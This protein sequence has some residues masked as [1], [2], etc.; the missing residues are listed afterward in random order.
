MSG[1]TLT[2]GTLESGASY[3]PTVTGSDEIEVIFPSGV[4]VVGNATLWSSPR[5]YAEW[6]DARR[7]DYD[8]TVSN[9][10]R[11]FTFGDPINALEFY[12][13][14]PETIQV[15]IGYASAVYDNFR[16]AQ[17]RFSS[18]IEQEIAGYIS[19]EIDENFNRANRKVRETLENLL[20]TLGITTAL[21]KAMRGVVIVSD[22]VNRMLSNITDLMNRGVNLINSFVRDKINLVNG[23]INS[24]YS[25]ARQVL[26]TIISVA[27]VPFDMINEIKTRIQNTIRRVELV[28]NGKIIED[29]RKNFSNAINIDNVLS[30]INTN[31]NLTLPSVFSNSLG[32]LFSQKTS[33]FVS[34]NLLSNLD[35]FVIGIRDPL[36]FSAAETFRRDIR[37]N[38]RD[39]VRPIVERHV[40]DTKQREDVI[41]IIVDEIDLGKDFCLPSLVQCSKG[42][43]AQSTNKVRD[44]FELAFNDYFE[45]IIRSIDLKPCSDQDR[46][47]YLNF[48]NNVKNELE[49]NLSFEKRG[50]SLEEKKRNEDYLDCVLVKGYD[51]MRREDLQNKLAEIDEILNRNIEIC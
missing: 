42:I 5:A 2:Q 29:L 43:K 17:T 44:A 31:L 10:T 39:K 36:G 18:F 13:S 51:R 32:S 35:Q 38:V 50:V 15:P 6:I 24:V 1:N 23:F 49:Q 12:D 19:A 25:S 16:E 26:N 20:A 46:Q 47:D 14:I 33:S 8:R 11:D 21:D 45:D 27:R 41:D 30:K 40:T 34:P 3:A 4:R 9:V 7:D 28:T 48:L 37:R 22:T